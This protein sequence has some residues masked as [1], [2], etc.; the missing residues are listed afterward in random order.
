MTASEVLH[1]VITV[2]ISQLV[3]DLLA[4][5]F[6]FKG[7][8]YTRLIEALERARWNLGK[9]EADAAKNPTK[10]GKR[11]LRAQEDFSAAGGNVSSRHVGPSML[12]SIY[13]LILLRILG[14]EYKGKLL[15][16]LPFIPF[17]FLQ[18]V[19]TR[20]FNWSNLDTDTAFEGVS[21]SYQQGVSFLFIY[22]LSALSVKVVVNRLV[23]TQPPPGADRGV[24]GFLESPQGKRIARGFGID[25]DELLKKD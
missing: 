23:G 1:I 13:F 6:V 4:N 19:T 16:V 7:E 20:G 2:G 12:G 18:R 8:N 25:P 17:K 24:M 5:Y 10:H 3:I 15:A 21:V 9:A 11:L 22:M 14:A